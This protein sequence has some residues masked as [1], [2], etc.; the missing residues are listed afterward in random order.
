MKFST[1]RKN[2][3]CPLCGNKRAKKFWAMSGYRLA[4]CDICAMVWDFF[5]PSNQLA[6][7]DESYFINENPKGGYANYFEGMRINKK[8]FLERLKKIENK[9]GKKGK[10]LDVGCALGDCLVEAKKLGWKNAK[11]LE[12]SDYAFKIAKKR[13][14]KV[15]R[16]VLEENYFRKGSFDVVLYQDV[17]EHIVNPVAEL[18]K[19]Y[20]ILKPGGLIFIVTPDIEGV[21][22]RMLGSFWYH[23]KPYEHLSYF[24]QKTIKLLLKQSG[25]ANISTQPTYHILSL[26]YILNRL[27]FYTP[28]LFDFLLR[29]IRKTPFKIASFRAYIGELEAWG[30]KPV[31][32]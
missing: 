1:K 11:G 4:K 9:Y 15:K 19:V 20:E 2:N 27:K 14:L 22:S 32:N 30:Q 16:G 23:Y 13:N 21:W 18:K 31:K 28:N 6:V 17:I 3:T 7:Y 25:F 8:T 24:S 29:V 10:I 26:E 5:P 12:V